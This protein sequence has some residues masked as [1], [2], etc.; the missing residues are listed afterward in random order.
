MGILEA[1]PGPGLEQFGFVIHQKSEDP[2]VF[3]GNPGE[4]G[5][6][7]QMFA[8]PSLVRGVIREHLVFSYS[9]SD[10]QCSFEKSWFFTC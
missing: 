8:F 6:T 4:S 2:S 7:E 3:Q 1:F 5:W 9:S 10:F